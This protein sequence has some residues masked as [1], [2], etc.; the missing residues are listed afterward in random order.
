MRMQFNSDILTTNAFV[1]FREDSLTEPSGANGYLTDCNLLHIIRLYA[2][3]ELYSSPTAPT[4][5][6]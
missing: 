3:D 1:F 2:Q 6:I 4:E 5:L